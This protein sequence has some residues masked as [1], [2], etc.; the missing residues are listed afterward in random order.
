MKDG[1]LNG[2]HVFSIK[3]FFPSEMSCFHAVVLLIQLKLELKPTSVSVFTFE[4]IGAGQDVL[5]C[6]VV[7]QV[8]VHHFYR[9]TQ[10]NKH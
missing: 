4:S 10:T 2:F 8:G 6:L 5:R 1:H 9:H 7:L 3:I